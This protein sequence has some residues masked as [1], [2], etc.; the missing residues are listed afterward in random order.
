[1]TWRE[2]GV[3][4][5]GHRHEGLWRCRCGRCNVVRATHERPLGPGDTTDAKCL[6][7]QASRRRCTDN[8]D[9]GLGHERTHRP[10][11]I[12]RGVHRRARQ[13]VGKGD[14]QRGVAG[15]REGQAGR[16]LRWKRNGRGGECR[17]G[18][19]QRQAAAHVPTRR[20]TGW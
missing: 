6:V 7:A 8:P 20:H 3:G 1:M 4:G 17:R 18:G 12:E 16:P 13:F 5:C 19:E 9:T 14:D 15:G 10:Q 2:V 11:M